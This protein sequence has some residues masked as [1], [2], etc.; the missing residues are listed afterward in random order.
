M[1]EQELKMNNQTKSRP[2]SSP[3]SSSSLS[4]SGP[5]QLNLVVREQRRLIDELNEKTKRLEET[6][7]A[8]RLELEVM[9]HKLSRLQQ[10]PQP[11]PTKESSLN[12]S[13]SSWLFRKNDPNNNPHTTGGNAKESVVHRHTSDY[14]GSSDGFEEIKL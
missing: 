7:D 13:S 14:Y 1:L 11:Q 9:E 5:S 2:N 4:N 3:S 6:L 10:Q 8:K 12:F